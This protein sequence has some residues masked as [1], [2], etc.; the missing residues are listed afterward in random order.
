[1]RDLASRI[2]KRGLGVHRATVA[3]PQ[4]FSGTALH[5]RSQPVKETFLC[6]SDPFWRATL[7]L[8]W[9]CESPEKVLNVE[10]GELHRARL[11]VM[12]GPTGPGRWPTGRAES[13]R[14][15]FGRQPTVG[16]PVQRAQGSTMSQYGTLVGTSSALRRTLLFIS[17][18]PN[19]SDKANAHQDSS[20]TAP[21]D[22]C[23]RDVSAS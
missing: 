16:P 3:R 17:R 4:P 15:I 14:R 13:L 1:L 11:S 5:T 12:R 9:H 8:L 6:H 7:C 10:A 20:E 22:M 21:T 23:V 18:Q 2:F 19:D